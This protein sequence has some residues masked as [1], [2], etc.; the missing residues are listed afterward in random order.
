[1]ENESAFLY[2]CTPTDQIGT[3]FSITEY[4]HSLQNKVRI[5]L[6]E[7]THQAI[8]F[9][10]IR[11]QFIS[12]KNAFITLVCPYPQ[13]LAKHFRIFSSTKNLYS[14]LL[15]SSLEVRKKIKNQGYSVELLIRWAKSFI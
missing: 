6:A 13:S 7:S 5:R 1:M 14:E 10:D 15:N 2:N 3:G 8:S 11:L 4:N 9:P 12:V